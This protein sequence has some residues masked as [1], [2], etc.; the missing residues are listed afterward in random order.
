[1][2]LTGSIIASVCLA[3]PAAFGL[4]WLVTGWLPQ[5]KKRNAAAQ[6]H[7]KRALQQTIDA[8]GDDT[9]TVRI[10]ER[11]GLDEAYWETNQ[12]QWK[13]GGG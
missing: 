13:R 8:I 7:R 4:A 6:A 9:N 5:G 2:T 12:P 11:I 10:I 1:M 3:Y